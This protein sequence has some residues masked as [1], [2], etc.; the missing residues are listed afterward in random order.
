MVEKKKCESH[1]PNSVALKLKCM[2]ESPGDPIKTQSADG[3]PLWL[4]SCNSYFNIAVT[5]YLTET[6]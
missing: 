2:A 3:M 5:K 1:W 4:S 6:T